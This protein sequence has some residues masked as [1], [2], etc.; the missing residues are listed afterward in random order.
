MTHNISFE[1]PLTLSG[2]DVP[3]FAD[4]ITAS[5]GDYVADVVDQ[6]LNKRPDKVTG[7]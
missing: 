3:G 4:A 1:G 7:K 2:I 5:L 6:K